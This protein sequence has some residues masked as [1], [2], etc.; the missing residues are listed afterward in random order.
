MRILMSMFG[1]RD[2][3]GGT[4]M[5]RQTAL[6]L[7]ERG[8]EV[9]VIYAGVPKIADQPAYTIHEHH[10]DGIHLIGIH[11]RPTVFLDLDNP[12]RECHD[13]NIKKI[14]KFYFDF[15]KPDVV[16]YHNFLGL[17]ISI[18]DLAYE[19]GTPNFYTP[20]NFW[21]LCPTLYLN[22]PDS[23][24]CRGVNASGSNCV[25]CACTHVP[26]VEYVHRRDQLRALYSERIGHGLATSECVRD[27]LLE[28]GYNA[29]KVEI[30]KLANGRATRLWQ[31]VGQ[32]RQP[33][34]NGRVRIGFMG[35]L[36]P[37]K[38]VHLL[39]QAVQVLQGDFQLTI[40][41]HGP[42]AYMD[43]LKQLD[44]RNIVH[45]AGYFDDAEHGNLLANIDVAVVPS[46]CFDHSPLVISEFLAA[47][48]PVVGAD[49]GGIPD[50][51]PTGM[52]LLYPADQ[53]LA[54]ANILQALIDQPS[55]IAAMQAHIVAPPSF[56][57][58]VR[59]LE[60]RY[61]AAI[62]NINE[63][64]LMQRIQHALRLGETL[65]YDAHTMRAMVEPVF[66]YGLDLRTPDALER[67]ST[68]I[69]QGARWIA[70]ADPTL[71]PHVES[72]AATVPHAV[73]LPLRALPLEHVTFEIPAPQPHKILL[74]L[75]PGDTFW[76]EALQAY[77]THAS[78]DMVC[79]LL[80]WGQSLEAA[81]EQLLHWLDEHHIDSAGGPELLLLEA[82]DAQQVG[83]LLQL[84][85][86]LMA[87]SLFLQDPA[88]REHV[89]LASW[90]MA[91][92]LSV[93]L[94]SQVEAVGLPEPYAQL[95]T[96][97]PH[98]QAYQAKQSAIEQNQASCQA[99]FEL[100]QALG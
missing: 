81:Q 39:V 86:L 6:Q 8:H 26:G 68:D 36:V 44:T 38:G 90:L 55:K 14:F 32:S 88:M 18:A 67:L 51:I 95:Q 72:V 19:S 59:S 61:E 80:P 10:E 43:Q 35:Q 37:I 15:F 84:V 3:G 57:D 11:N 7:K 66:P 60:Q 65:F 100:V 78:P 31:E 34:V 9:M 79:V 94:A 54:L 50:Y 13:P 99:W 41:G 64:Q 5:P 58:Y 25:E 20:Y 33:G 24:L 98:W 53:P 46:I 12:R 16:H 22:L 70:L 75:C 89:L 21:L 47:R 85:G 40:Y 17:S 93:V 52:G 73:V 45:F 56:E 92:E 77:W 63:Q 48:I 62:A 71:Q 30:L 1:W 74:P 83:H 23:S 4:I 69:I 27:L 42:S 49:I 96:H 91:P 82:Q 29:D 28:N 87:S 2:A 97:L 76:S